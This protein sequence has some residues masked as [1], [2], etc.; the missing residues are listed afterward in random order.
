MSRKVI[1]I[2]EKRSFSDCAVGAVPK[3]LRVDIRGINADG[4]LAN[5]NIRLKTP[6]HILN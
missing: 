1:M 2:L 5:A 3:Y 6:E 4:K